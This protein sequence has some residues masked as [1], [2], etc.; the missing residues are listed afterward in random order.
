M[1]DDDGLLAY[2]DTGS[3][4]PLVLVHGLTFSRRTWDPAVERLA[5]RFRCVAVDLPG[6][7]DSSGSG[8]DPLQVVDRL[9]A[10]LEAI[11]VAD[12]V[13]VGHS[14]GTMVA[15][16]YGARYPVRGVV[17]VD[18]PLV[19]GPF[20]GFVQQLA[21][22]LHGPDFGA[23]FA[24]FE[25]S[26]GVDR[27]PEPERTRVV[28]TRQVEQAVVLDHWHTPLTT[29]PPQMQALVDGLLDAVT[30]PF[31]YVAAEEP[32]APVREHLAAHLDDLE[33]VVMPPGGGHLAHLAHPDRFAEVLAGFA[34][35]VVP[36]EA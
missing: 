25:E 26:I 29:P 30:T 28:G 10:T 1:A 13:V 21:D 16:G 2:D 17:D 33:V 31:L 24:P 7:G 20:A 12:P 4:P 23:A 35:R 19:V 34:G 18:Q 8:A 9:H 14:A 36:P 15:L 5:D 3:G 27:L 22:A 6:H 32:P 11:G